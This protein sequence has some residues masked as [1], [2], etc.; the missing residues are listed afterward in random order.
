MELQAAAPA[1]EIPAVHA[2]QRASLRVEELGLYTISDGER[3]ALVYLTNPIIQ[4]VRHA[5]RER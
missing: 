5:M 2:G 4:A 1:A 3:T